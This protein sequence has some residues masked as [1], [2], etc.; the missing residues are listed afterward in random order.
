MNLQRTYAMLLEHISAISSEEQIQC[1]PNGSESYYLQMHSEFLS[2]D[3]KSKV[4]RYNVHDYLI[5]R[6][7]ASIISKMEPSQK[8]VDLHR[9]LLKM[10]KD[11]NYKIVYQTKKEIE[12]GPASSA[13]CLCK[14]REWCDEKLFK[15]SVELVMEIGQKETPNEKAANIEESI[16]AAFN[17]LFIAKP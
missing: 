9:I 12:A 5:R 6:I 13:S 7:H 3:I 10:S 4:L 1:Q 16:T 8:D 15:K 11:A 17:A 2:K 14:H